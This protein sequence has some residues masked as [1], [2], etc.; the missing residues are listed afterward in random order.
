[1]KMWSD[2]ILSYSKHLGVYS[3]SLGELYASPICNNENISRRLSME[4][5]Q[6][7]CAWMDT[8]KFGGFTA[9]S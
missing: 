5:L 7:V 2:L 9:E 6:K 3:I 8:N 4:S 1:M